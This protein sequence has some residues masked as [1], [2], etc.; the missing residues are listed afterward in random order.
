VIGKALS[1]FWSRGNRA[2]RTGYV[3]AALLTA[4]GLVHLAILIVSGASW[5]GPLSLRKATTFGL[6][7]GMTLTTITWVV[8]FLHLS[9]RTRTRLLAAFTVACALET[10]LVTLQV[11]RGVPSHFNLETTFDAWVARTLAAGGMALVVLILTFTVAAFRA[12]PGVPGSLLTA[13]RFG[14]VTLIGAIGVG[15]LMI[16][17][18]MAL[19]LEGNPQAAYAT[20]GVLKPTHAVTMH[21]ILVLPALAWLL[22]F[23]DWSERR[24]V[25]VVRAGAAG[26]AVFAGAIAVGN[27]GG[28]DLKSTSIAA[29]TILGALSLCATG[30]LVIRSVAHASTGDG[31]QHR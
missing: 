8:S 27:V 4:S 5:D 31:I 9:N 24:R 1:S 14:F 12:N 16:A 6:S 10:A 7:F 15:A 21:A 20:G 17:R 3:V 30:L 28:F 25:Q 18:G 13:V 19:V 2:E 11:W 29:A 23:T 22:S 26:Y